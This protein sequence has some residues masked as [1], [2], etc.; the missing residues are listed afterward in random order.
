MAKYV[1][2]LTSG[3]DSPGLNAALRGLASRH[4]DR[5]VVQ[6]LECN[7]NARGDGGFDGKLSTVEIGAV[8][9]I[10]ENVGRVDEL[11]HADPGGPLVSHCG[12]AEEFPQA[13]VV[14]EYRHGM[15]PDSRAHE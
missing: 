15:A 5:A 8:A 13:F 6:H 11:G 4:G 12:N 9:K 7:I 10:L 2:V 3:G 1:G 14:H